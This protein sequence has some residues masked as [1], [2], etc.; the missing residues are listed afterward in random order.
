MSF[1]GMSAVATTSITVVSAG[2]VKSWN[3]PHAL[4]CGESSPVKVV[5]SAPAGPD[6]AVA[7]TAATT[8]RD[9]RQSE[10]KRHSRLPDRP[11]RE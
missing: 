11:R 5:V 2:T 1:D 4:A 3:G 9:S 8:D 6:P 10:P 7:A